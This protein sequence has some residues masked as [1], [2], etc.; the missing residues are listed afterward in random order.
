MYTLEQAD[1]YYPLNN[2]RT[3]HIDKDFL[4]REMA[5][6]GFGLPITLSYCISA[7]AVIGAILWFAR[8]K[9]QK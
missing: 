1:R 8:W 5:P 3:T 4:A 7:A 9:S 6:E 2:L